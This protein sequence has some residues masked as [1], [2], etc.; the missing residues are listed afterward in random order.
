MRC[1]SAKTLE[2]SVHDELVKV[3][4]SY[5]VCLI[6]DDTLSDERCD[7]VFEQLRRAQKNYDE[8]RDYVDGDCVD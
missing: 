4:T 3:V 5:Q 8:A 6:H 1:N 2:A 7:R